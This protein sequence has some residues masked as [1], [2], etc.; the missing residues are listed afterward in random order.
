[1]EGESGEQVGAPNCS[2]AA[3]ALPQTL[4]GSSQY[5]P[6]PLAGKGEGK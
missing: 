4:L 5:F 6:K 2:A 1:M 3:G